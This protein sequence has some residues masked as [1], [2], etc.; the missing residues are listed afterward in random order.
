MQSL[1]LSVCSAKQLSS[2]IFCLPIFED[3]Y[4]PLV[5]TNVI[6][7][8]MTVFFQNIFVMYLKLPLTYIE[9]EI[10]DLIHICRI[11]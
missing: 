2:R 8:S 7:I 4:L 9:V 6:I 1:Y 3:P 10:N 5:K 11:E